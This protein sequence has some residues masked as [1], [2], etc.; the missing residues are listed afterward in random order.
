MYLLRVVQEDVR[1]VVAPPDKSPELLV[2][3]EMPE[4]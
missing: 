3:D 2:R 4:L 1:P